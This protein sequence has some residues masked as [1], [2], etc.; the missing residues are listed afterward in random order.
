MNGTPQW[1]FCMLPIQKLFCY[2]LGGEGGIPYLLE[3]NAQIFY[4]NINFKRGCVLNSNKSGISA[5]DIDFA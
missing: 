4:Q 2:F 5:G 1:C 3:Y